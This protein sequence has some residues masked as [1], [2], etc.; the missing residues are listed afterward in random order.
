MGLILLSTM[1]L[2]LGTAALE[3]NNNSNSSLD[4][5][6]AA[7][8]PVLAAS[9]IPPLPPEYFEW[10]A[11]Y[12]RPLP[13][14]VAPL[15]G[16]GILDTLETY[17]AFYNKTN[18]SMLEAYT[19]T[20]QAGINTTYRF[21]VNEVCD[22]GNRLDGDGCA[23][24]CASMDGMT[25]PCPLVASQLLLATD[26]D[27]GFEFLS[28]L[29]LASEANSSQR[30]LMA[31][32]RRRIML[33]DPATL[34][35][36]RVLLAHKNF[37][38]TLGIE[39]QGQIRLFSADTGTLRVLRFENDR[40]AI[41]TILT[42]R[43][44]FAGRRFAWVPFAHDGVAVGLLLLRLDTMD[45]LNARDGTMVGDLA[46]M[47]G[48]P[49]GDNT[50][51]VAQ[52]TLV[53][54][55]QQEE[56]VVGFQVQCTLTNAYTMMFWATFAGGNLISVSNGT[57][58]ASAEEGSF[59]SGTPWL[60]LF[61]MVIARLAT[62]TPT[63][64]SVLRYQSTVTVTTDLI[65]PVS[66]SV[67]EHYE[68]NGDLGGGMALPFAIYSV[69]PSVRQ[70]LVP[71]S[72]W[73]QGVGDPLVRSIGQEQGDAT[74]C[75][76]RRLCVLDIPVCAN[77]LQSDDLY[78]GADGGRTY[79]TALAS[80][81][82][83][84]AAPTSPQ[85]WY[86]LGMAAAPRQT[87]NATAATTVQQMLQHPVTDALWLV[88]RRGLYEVGRRGT[89]FFPEEARCAP[90]YSGPCA[91]G[92][93]S[94]PR[95]ACRPCA[96][97][98]VSE[99]GEDMVAWAQRCPNHHTTRRSLLQQQQQEAILMSLVSTRL[100]SSDAATGF[101]LNALLA[102]QVS[103]GGM[104]V[105]C[106]SA[107]AAGAWRF[108]ANCTLGLPLVNAP[109]PA[110]VLRALAAAVLNQ[111]DTEFV[112]APRLVV[113]STATTTTTTPKN[114]TDAAAAEA[115]ALAAAAAEA[116]TMLAITLCV[117]GGGALLLL[118]A[119]GIGC[120]SACGNGYTALRAG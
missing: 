61:M 63:T 86:D 48:P 36:E 67:W 40:M 68:E 92:M 10:Y 102:A 83:S 89:Q 59:M 118:A 14:T 85:A 45:A 29:T 17:A 109:D 107:Q 56:G 116:A 51:M 58:W 43:Q 72:A 23:A 117:V 46:A 78:A 37:T 65:P 98:P 35:V 64:R 22:D 32:T 80:T 42:T 57:D 108:A 69:L 115:A 8:D 50:S 91:P 104:T 11:R 79:Y 114:A 76:D 27:D 70:D 52:T 25:S 96:V 66:T 16:N 28:F 31:I 34:A 9:M 112:S 30:W 62:V 81:V 7:T 60:G 95:L 5:I 101:V 49:P 90:S 2:V 18:A 39:D 55:I 110:R 73:L 94:P 87:C 75:T 33:A 74:V 105:G 21:A 54:V 6:R 84:S 100:T 71:Y 15:C 19:T 26:A 3:P 12:A 47:P 119:V 4:A 113:T 53:S 13:P 77:V 120:C 41:V 99:E 24:D 44:S 93:W 103:I 1:M 97:R 111:T 82:G 106:A 20:S 88:T 38:V